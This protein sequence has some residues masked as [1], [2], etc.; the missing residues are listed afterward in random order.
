MCQRIQH[1]E[2]Q[3]HEHMLQEQSTAGC[4]CPLPSKKSWSWPIRGHPGIFLS[5]SAQRGPHQPW[6]CAEDGGED[7]MPSRSWWRRWRQSSRNRTFPR[8]DGEVR[9][10]NRK[11]QSR[12]W[13]SSRASGQ[14]ILFDVSVK[15]ESFVDRYTYRLGHSCRRCCHIG[16]ECPTCRHRQS[17]CTIR[18]ARLCLRC[19]S[20][21]GRL[22]MSY[23]S[24]ECGR[25]RVC[26]G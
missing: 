15:S 14:P 8:E 10:T 23:P 22:S 5:C 1:Q 4:R 12:Q 7:R 24:G 11:S 9:K 2:R 20:T 16:T 17:C 25:E 18:E 26:R 3:R 21:F 13:R 19:Q 6:A